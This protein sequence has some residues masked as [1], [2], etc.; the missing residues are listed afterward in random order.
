MKLE[1]MVLMKWDSEGLHVPQLLCKLAL[2]Q[3]FWTENI[4]L[5]SCFKTA[6]ASVITI[7]TCIIKQH[8]PSVDGFPEHCKNYNGGSE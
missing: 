6:F 7:S 2:K 3:I 5:Y 1:P 8:C 4:M